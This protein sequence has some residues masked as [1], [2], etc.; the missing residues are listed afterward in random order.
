MKTFKFDSDPTQLLQAVRQL[1][2]SN[3]PQVSYRDRFN[4]EDHG[5]ENDVLIRLPPD[6]YQPLI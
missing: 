2:G 1:K 3:K 4:S 6:N 5:F